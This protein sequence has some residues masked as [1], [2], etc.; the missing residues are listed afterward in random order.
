MEGTERVNDAEGTER[1]QDL[2]KKAHEIRLKG[3]NCAETT[4]WALGQYW[5]EDLKPCYGTGLGGGVARLG[6]TCGA[7]TGAIVA[8]SARVG[9]TDPADGEKKAL[10][11]RLG[12]EVAREFKEAM[13]TTQCREIIGFVPSGEGI[14]PQWSQQFR[15]GRCGKAIEVAIKAAIRAMEG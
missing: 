12:Q 4:I 5:N 7:L 2:L 3:L 14:Q 8:M 15:T 6:E 11:Y 1:I 9:R 13:G 10:C